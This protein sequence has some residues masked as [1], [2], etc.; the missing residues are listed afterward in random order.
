M[1]LHDFDLIYGSYNGM[2][3]YNEKK[4]HYLPAILNYF[5]FFLSE[6]KSFF[7]TLHALSLI[8]ISMLSLFECIT[9]SS[10]LSPSEEKNINS[11]C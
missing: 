10:S 6:W 5:I 7:I 11:Y 3:E 9:C 8:M 2:T 1:I 4:T